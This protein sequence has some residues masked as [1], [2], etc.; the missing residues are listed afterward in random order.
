MPSIVS[1]RPSCLDMAPEWIESLARSCPV[2]PGGVH[3]WLASF[4]ARSF[5]HLSAE[6]QVKILYWATA[7]CGRP[8]QANEI[9]NTVAN[10]RQWR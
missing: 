9:E 7:H 4:V 5:N 8:M 2:S 6:E 3:Q 1:V 10:V